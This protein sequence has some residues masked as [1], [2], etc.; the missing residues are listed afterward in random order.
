MS[1]STPPGC[2][3]PVPTHRMAPFSARLRFILLLA[4]VSM[5]VV[6]LASMAV[7]AVAL[8]QGN[9]PV[10]LTV[11]QGSGVQ[12][13][14]VSGLWGGSVTVYTR[15]PVSDSPRMLGCELV[16]ADGDQASGTRIG[17]FDFALGDPVTVDGT[18]W[19]PFTEIDL[20]SAPTTLRCSGGVLTSA[21]VSE[22]STF[23]RSS[24]FIG[25]FALGSGAIGLILGVV[26]LITARMVRPTR[27]HPARSR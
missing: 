16:E 20:R 7:G 4:G 6:G 1:A 25:Y 27:Q 9:D 26:A 23:G 24:S 8:A 3:S 5:V 2:G 15:E 18:T 14:A 19:Y 10:R 21:A 13:P 12:V 17:N 22:Q 11:A